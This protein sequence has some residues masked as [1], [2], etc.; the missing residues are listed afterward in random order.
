ME[1]YERIAQIRVLS[2]SNKDAITMILSAH[3][4]MATEKGALLSVKKFDDAAEMIIKFF[5]IDGS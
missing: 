3:A 5:H 4:D 1:F 2:R